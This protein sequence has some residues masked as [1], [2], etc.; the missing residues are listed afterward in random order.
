MLPLGTLLLVTGIS[1]FFGTFGDRQIP[2]IDIV[3]SCIGIV[4]TVN[5]QLSTVN[6]Q[7]STVN[8]L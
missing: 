8:R 2:Q 7:L 4:E 1:D 3:S 6:C 5:C